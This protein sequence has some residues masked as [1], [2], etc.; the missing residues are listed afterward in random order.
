MIKLSTR[1]LDCRFGS[2]G[3][4]WKLRIRSWQSELKKLPSVGKRWRWSDVV[5]SERDRAVSPRAAHAVRAAFNRH[6]EDQHVEY[7]VSE[8]LEAYL[9]DEHDTVLTGEA[10]KKDHS[11]TGEQI[12]TTTEGRDNL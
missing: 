5:D 12:D 2:S 8:A 9:E 11:W 7:E 6:E 10:L 4:S 1:S 3:R